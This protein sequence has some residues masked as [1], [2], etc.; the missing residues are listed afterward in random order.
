MV[1]WFAGRIGNESVTA[2][3]REIAERVDAS[4]NGTGT[5]SARRGKSGAENVGIALKTSTTAA[6]SAGR[7]GDAQRAAWAMRM[8]AI[9]RIW[10]HMLLL[11]ALAKLLLALASCLMALSHKQSV[12]TCLMVATQK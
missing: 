3:A 8:V 2:N 9:A 5:G 7:Q 4:R 12:R 6:K 1:T 11:L 10:G